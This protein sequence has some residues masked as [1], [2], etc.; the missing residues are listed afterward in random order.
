MSKE[1]E[2][3]KT[4]PLSIEGYTMQ[5]EKEFYTYREPNEWAISANLKHIDYPYS[6]LSVG[7][8]YSWPDEYKRPTEAEAQLEIEDYLSKM[9]T[10]EEAVDKTVQWWA[11]K[12]FST[13]FNQ[14]NGDNSSA[15]GLMFALSN[16][17]SMNGQKEATPEKIEVFKKELK[18]KM[19]ADEKYDLSV[20]Y[21]GVPAL[22]ESCAAAGLS[23]QCLP[24]KTHSRID[25]F[26]NVASAAFGYH[27]KTEYL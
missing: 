12:S 3:I 4:I 24:I 21:H 1:N 15:G 9:G 7:M 6:I 14:N 2:I 25:R 27:G 26:T 23:D 10:F 16:L 18:A 11:D 8:E 19:M 5:I 17:S 22:T 13:L 20:D